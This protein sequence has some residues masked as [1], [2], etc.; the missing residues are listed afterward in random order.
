MLAP[1]IYRSTDT[2]APVLFG[3]GGSLI[4]LL[5]AILVNGYGSAFSSGTITIDA[6]QPADGD[7]VT[8]GSITYTFRTSL[9]AQPAYAVAIGGSASA[10]F[11]NL[12]VAINQNGIASA[13]YSIGTLANPDAYV[14]SATATVL[15]LVARKGGSAGNS[16][17]LARTAVGAPHYSV[18]GTT[19]TGGGGS[20]T[21]ASAGWTKAYGTF[22]QAAYRQPAGCRFYLQVD[23]SGPGSDGAKEARCIGWEAMT[24]YNTGLGQFPTAAQVAARAVCRKSTTIDSVTRAWIAFVDDRTV[25][26]FVLSGD[27]AGNYHGFSF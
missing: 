23:D 27:A 17:A 18:S 15:T 7:T 26:L 16:I 19:L 13:H 12:Q 20:D 5:D 24:A 11:T 9:T 22:P 2:N 14:S 25:Y 1:A 8:I 10:A 6:S 4:T 21:K 3:G